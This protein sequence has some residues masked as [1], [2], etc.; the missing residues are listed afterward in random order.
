M[1]LIKKYITDKPKII[2]TVRPIIDI[3]TSFISILPEESYIDIEMKQAN[4]WHKDY[5]S[6]NDNRCDYLMR[7]WGQIDQTLFV[8]NQIINEPQTFCLIEYDKIINSPQKTMDK[9]YKFI[10]LPNYEHNFN[11]IVKID[12]HND[13]EIGWPINMH[14]VRPKL[15]KIS[16]NPKEILS[17][18]VISKYSN[19][20]W[21]THKNVINFS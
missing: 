20:G 8:I 6:K 7:P 14:E 9:I 1:D 11:H 15:N 5:L 3:L 2:F 16:K 19:I 17:D 18:Y 21:N 12:K 13:E 4:W 10:N